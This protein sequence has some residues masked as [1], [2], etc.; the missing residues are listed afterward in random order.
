MVAEHDNEMSNLHF[1]CHPPEN[2]TAENLTENCQ[3]DLDI[4][5]HEEQASG[6]TL[7][8]AESASPPGLREQ[9]LHFS[10]FKA[11]IGRNDGPNCSVAL[12]CSSAKRFGKSTKRA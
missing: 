2:G 1:L 6:L 10:V 12:Y 4:S 3:L 11:H 8:P 9:T 5:F 7:L